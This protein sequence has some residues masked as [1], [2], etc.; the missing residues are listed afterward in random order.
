MPD[1]K[2]TSDSVQLFLANILD[3]IN[4]TRDKIDKISENQVA[5]NDFER[6]QD[7][8]DKKFDD[9]EENFDKIYKKISDQLKINSDFDTRLIVGDLFVSNFKWGFRVFVGAVLA[10]IIALVPTYC[11]NLKNV[12]KINQTLP[13][14]SPVIQIPSAPH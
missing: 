14:V 1:S 2:I 3:Q 12:S 13:I 7:K 10:I 6:F 5:I 4:V 8:L 11:A 9:V